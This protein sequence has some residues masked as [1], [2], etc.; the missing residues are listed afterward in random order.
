MTDHPHPA[1][2]ASE[3]PTAPQQG[4]AGPAVTAPAGARASAR[5]P[6]PPQS[7]LGVEVLRQVFLCGGLSARGLP[8]PESLAGGG[9]WLPEGGSG[10]WCQGG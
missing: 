3:G 8:V 1:A 5:P 9:A 2:A 7:L 10:S 6:L 4:G